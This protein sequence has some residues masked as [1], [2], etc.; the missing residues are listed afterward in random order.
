MFRPEIIT[1]FRNRF[2]VRDGR[3]ITVELI[4]IWE[5]YPAE[6]KVFEYFGTFI[7]ECFGY[8]VSDAIFRNS[9]NRLIRTMYKLPLQKTGS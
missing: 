1:L 2:R 5:H 9:L 7:H 6:I 4:T 8:G 3:L